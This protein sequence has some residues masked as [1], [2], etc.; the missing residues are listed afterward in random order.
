MILQI[1]G[2]DDAF[3]PTNETKETLVLLIN[4]SQSPYFSVKIVENECYRRPS[5]PSLVWRWLVFHLLRGRRTVWVFHPPWVQWKPITKLAFSDGECPISKISRKNRGLWPAYVV[6]QSNLE[7]HCLIH[8]PTEML[9]KNRRCFWSLSWKKKT[10]PVQLYK[11]L[12]IN[13]AIRCILLPML[14]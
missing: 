10:K 1:H 3:S 9:V 8:S 11:M 6:D 13:Q 14:N 2:E 7:F 12:S 4:C 5:W